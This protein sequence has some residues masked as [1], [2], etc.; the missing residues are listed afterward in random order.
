MKSDRRFILATLLT[1]I[2]ALALTGTGLSADDNTPRKGQLRGVLTALKEDG[3]SWVHQGTDWLMKREFVNHVLFLSTDKSGS[4][5]GS[6]MFHPTQI[7][8]GWE[9]LQKRDRN[10]DGVISFEEFGGSRELFDILD[11]NRDGVLTKAD[12]DWSAG[13]VLANAVAKGAPLF[14]RI[15]RDANGHIT[16]EEWKLWFET[17]SGGKGYL[18]QDDLIP[19]FLEPNRG[20]GGPQRSRLHLVC[21][22]LAGDVGP[23][24]DGPELGDLAPDF[25]LTTADGKGKQS[26]V[27]HQAKKPQVLVFG[28]F[29]CNRFRAQYGDVEEVY[30]R[31]KDK[32]DFIAV[33]LREA[34]PTDGWALPY[35]EKAGISIAQ[36]KAFEERRTA[37]NTCCTSLK[38]SIPL[39]VDELDD[40]AG[41][42]YCGMPDRLYLLDTQGR[43]AYKGGR[44]PFG[45]RPLELEQALILFQMA[46]TQTQPKETQGNPATKDR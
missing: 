2:L 18:S 14:E 15:D 10:G 12:F 6:G 43:V 24:S 34:H 27:K 16:P 37:A 29:T 32:F 8:Y 20:R 11:K 5:V 25:S 39:L 21:A 42:A 33:Y 26:I 4:I 13:S 19:V 38:M 7:K 9:W 41:V 31:Y 30:Q 35:N 22:Y 45:Y 3:N 46:E 28:S 17:L 44:G 23:L 1:G 36:P 40:R